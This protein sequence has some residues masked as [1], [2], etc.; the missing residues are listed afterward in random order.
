MHKKYNSFYLGYVVQNND[1][2]RGGK[3]K[4]FVPAIM[5]TLGGLSSEIDADN[6]GVQIDFSNLSTISPAAL[7]QMKNAL[8]WAR[9]ISPLIGS[10]SPTI[11]NAR[12]HTTTTIDNPYWRRMFTT[13][14]Q[15][16]AKTDKPRRAGAIFRVLQFFLKGAFGASTT[17]DKDFGSIPRSPAADPDNTF[18][19]N[20][21]SNMAKGAFSIPSVGAVVWMFFENGEWDLPVY[22]G[23]QHSTSAWR[24]I[25]GPNGE[26]TP[27]G[28]EN[29]ASGAGS[30]GTGTSDLPSSEENFLGDAD[31]N[32]SAEDPYAYDGKTAMEREEDIFNKII[33]ETVSPRP[34]PNEVDA[35]LFPEG[36]GSSANANPILPRGGASAVDPRSGT[37]G[38]GPL[39]E[40][41]GPA[42]APPLQFFG[43]AGE[44]TTQP[45]ANRG[46][47]GVTRPGIYGPEPVPT[48]PPYRESGRPSGADPGYVPPK[49]SRPSSVGLQPRG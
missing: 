19:S 44:G 20:I 12:D 39:P 36:S 10:G 3:V 14:E 1:P 4:I 21:R 29:D 17:I 26:G 23:Y 33:G 42:T 2:D 18:N 38:A 30:G 47:G 40:G 22:F 28:Y 5:P 32:A 37:G 6:A 34:G 13:L 25:F 35:S 11:F 45:P 31:P 9:Q 43:P 15:L 27:G 16:G 48:A 41:G 8:P 46:I 24:E 49:P 7:A